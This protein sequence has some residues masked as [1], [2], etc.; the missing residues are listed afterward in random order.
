M[1]DDYD[2]LSYQVQC[3]KKWASAQCRVQAGSG[4]KEAHP[5][6]HPALVGLLPILAT[7]KTSTRTCIGLVSGF[8]HSDSN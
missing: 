8:S 7:C 2:A 5:E 6:Y 3:V 4:D 1:E